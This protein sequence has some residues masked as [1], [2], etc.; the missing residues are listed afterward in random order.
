MA[1][2]GSGNRFTPM[3]P[4]DTND[5]DKFQNAGVV[6]L[7]ISPRHPTSVPPFDFD[8]T[9]FDLVCQSPYYF[10]CDGEFDQSHCILDGCR[11]PNVQQQ[12]IYTLLWW[13]YFP[14]ESMIYSTCAD[15]MMGARGVVGFK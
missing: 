13:W 10:N 1:V 9:E 6:K 12:G 5:W 7:L 8:H 2:F 11:I 14:L 3:W 15:G 4:A